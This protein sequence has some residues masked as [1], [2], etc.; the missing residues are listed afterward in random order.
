MGIINLKVTIGTVNFTDWLHV[1]AA[2]VSNP[3]VPVFDT[4]IDVP[5]TNYNLIIPGL[6]P[7]NYIISYYDAPTN[8][9]LGQLRMQLIV[10]ALTNQYI[11]ERRFYVVG[12]PG[13][14]DPAD[15]ALQITD[16]YF[17]NKAVTGIFKEN[18][19]YLIPFT[20][21]DMT[22]NQVTTLGDTLSILTG[23]QLSAGEVVA[24]E[25]LL[26]AGVIQASGGSLYA[27]RVD[28]TDA[29]YTCLQA[30][31]KKRHRLVGTAATQVITLPSIAAMTQEDFYLF[32][33]SM[34]GV[35]VQCRILP[36]GTD[37]IQFDGFRDRLGDGDA[38][39]YE[40]WVSRGC[41]LMVAVVDDHWE[42]TI[43]WKGVCVGER[44]AS[45]TKNIP[46]TVMENG[47]IGAD[48]LDGD[49][50]PGLWFWL[51]EIHDSAYIIM[52]DTVINTSY[53]HPPGKEGYFVM[54]NTLKKFR[55]PNWQEMSEKSLKD[56]DNL[57]GTLIDPDRP[58]NYPGGKQ[59]QKMMKHRHFCVVPQVVSGGVGPNSALS[60]ATQNDSGPGDFKYIL[61][62][63]AA[64][65]ST[66]R[67]GF[68]V[69]AAGASISNGNNYVNTLGV[70]YL[71]RI[72]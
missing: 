71:R 22:T 10:N 64:E 43:D 11:A 52:D 63:H 68:P 31:K 24:V 54:H 16:P 58:N 53:V 67:T 42:I 72:G 60:I 62:G 6:D 65:P 13:A 34:G 66:A 39:L 70:I 59:D 35:A 9:A 32:D 1:S 19:R 37:F 49:E 44:F 45:T 14:N 27:G 7:E 41:R 61:F 36:D 46:N 56:Y 57:G 23:V 21:W 26:Q 47:Q 8:V 4:W 17:V 18:N 40:L 3:A 51:N 50:L 15:G 12:G 38:N 48:A 25:I 5:V 29:V 30:D 69:D 2:K 20:E 55:T 28:V 33:N